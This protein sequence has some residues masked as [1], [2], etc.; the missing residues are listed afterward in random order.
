MAKIGDVTTAQSLGRAGHAQYKFVACARCGEGRWK[1]TADTDTLCQKC[2]H[3]RKPEGDVKRASELGYKVSHRDYWL[4]RG[5]CPECGM[6]MWRRK[7]DL[8]RPCVHCTQRLLPRAT[9]TKHS[10]WNGGRRV[11]KDGYIEVTLSPDD[12]MRVMAR[13]NIVLEHRLVVARLIERP[14]KPWEIVHHI[15][16][17][18]DD[19]RPENLRLVEDRHLHQS[20]GIESQIIQKL[21]HLQS[22]IT[23]LSIQLTLI[24]ARLQTEGIW[25]SRASRGEEP[26]ASV[27]TLHG[28]SHVDEEKVQ[29][30]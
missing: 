7:A 15:N 9:M 11:R 30:P 27:E 23:N 20:I 3:Q 26:R 12:P 6:E 22:Q 18:R 28:A 4:H 25:E 29:T 14:L 16:R 5:Q 8:Q 10:R 2:S 17:Q 1:R 13:G 21:E 19:N 24:E